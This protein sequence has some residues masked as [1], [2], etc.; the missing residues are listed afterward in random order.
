MCVRVCVKPV[1]CF[2]ACACAS[3]ATTQH[4]NQI[5]FK[6]TPP[7]QKG[8]RPE[9]GGGA[10]YPNE[11]ASDFAFIPFG[12]GARKCVGDTFALFEAAVAFAMLLRRFRFSFAEGGPEAVGMATGATIHTANGMMMR[13]AERSSGGAG[14]SAQTAATAGATASV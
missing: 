1:C 2:F 11:V 12:G 5:K 8:Y 6:N 10:L 14:A 9:A 7:P 3:P 13:V 4:S